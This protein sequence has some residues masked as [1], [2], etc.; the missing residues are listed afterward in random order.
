MKKIE[1][2]IRIRLRYIKDGGKYKFSGEK[3]SLS[4]TNNFPDTLFIKRND[5]GNYIRADW[6]LIG[7]INY[8][9]KVHIS[10]LRRFIHPNP[11]K[12]MLESGNFLKFIYG[13]HMDFRSKKK[14][15]LFIEWTHND[16][17]ISYFKDWCPDGED[18]RDK[19]LEQIYD[20]H[21]EL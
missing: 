11:D 16:L 1:D 5:E 12:L 6:I 19:Y 20:K 9:K 17:R 8:R 15:F 7:I 3:K 14:S 2:V 18:E 13:D 21:F 10:G 4:L